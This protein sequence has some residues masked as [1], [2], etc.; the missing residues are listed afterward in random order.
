MDNYGKAY[1]EVYYAIN[2]F[3]DELKSKI[4]EDIINI[5]GNSM[6]TKYV[7]INSDMSE[8]AR[9]IL[10]IIYSDFL[11]TNEEKKIWSELDTLYKKSIKTNSYK[12]IEFNR[13]NYNSTRE[14]N[15]DESTAIAVID[16][17]SRIFGILKKIKRF[18]KSLWRD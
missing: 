4:P 17:K 7:P 9:A 3:S 18:L 8:E 13:R 15:K 2:N 16:K 6:D 11:C 1:T 5:I 14:D 12:G 10:S